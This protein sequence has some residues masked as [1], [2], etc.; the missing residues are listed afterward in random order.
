MCFGPPLG[1]GFGEA[2]H[3]HV[4]CWAVYKVDGPAR[5]CL[6]NEAIASVA[7]FRAFSVV[8][9]ALS[10]LQVQCG[11]VVKVTGILVKSKGKS[12]PMGLCNQI[13]SLAACV[14]AT[15]SASAVE[16]VTSSCFL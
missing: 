12:S 9:I 2:V 4:F 15:Y 5:Y 11:L 14:A 3:S 7:M 8:M 1:Q 6:W 16:K 10:E 13:A